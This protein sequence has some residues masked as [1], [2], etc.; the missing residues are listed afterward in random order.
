MK[1]MG[2]QIGDP[3]FLNTVRKFLDAG[4]IDPNTGKLVRSDV[5][6]PQGGILSPIL[7]NIVLHE[8]DKFMAKHVTSFQKGRRRR[9]NP[10]YKSLLAKRGRSKSP[11]E[12]LSLLRQMR[13]MRSADMFDPGFRRME[14]VRYADD[15]V[16]LMTGSLRDAGFIKNN[17]KDFL[18][19]NCGLDLN[20]DKTV[21]SNIATEK[22]KFLGAK[23]SKIGLN[24]S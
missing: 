17:V 7:S 5:G 18:K 19:S 16:I 13:T 3:A 8:F 12:K 21:I 24:S 23:I 20:S 9:W 4:Y 14:Y 22:W 6:A 15:F 2:T 1:R 10:A 11:K